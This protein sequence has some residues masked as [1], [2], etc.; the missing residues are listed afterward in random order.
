MKK[1]FLLL[2]FAFSFSFAETFFSEKYSIWQNGDYLLWTLDDSLA[3]SPSDFC[4]A[5]KKNN[6][7]I[8][9]PSCR[10]LGEWERDSVSVKY[11]KWLNN[12]FDKSLK[13]EFLKARSPLMQVKI[14][15]LED[16]IVLFL[17][18]NK[19]DIQIFLFNE[20]SNAP[21]ASGKIQVQENRIKTSDALVNEFFDKRPERRLSAKERKN[22]AEAPDP[23]YSEIP[24][25]EFWVGTS[26]AYSQARIPLTP[27]NWYR[28][29]INSKVKRYRVT[30]DSTSLWNF[31]EDE[32]AVLSF[33]GG[34]TWYG[35]FGGE[36]FYKY[37]N[38]EMKT[39]DS[40]TTYK[41]LSNWEIGM[42]ELGL[43][44]HITHTFHTLK[45]LETAP[46]F[47]FGFQYSFLTED[48]SLKKNVKKASDAYNTRIQFDDTYKGG[49]LGIGSRFLIKDSYALTLRAGV[50]TRGKSETSDPDLNSVKAPTTIGAITV[51][52]FISIGL[53]YHWKLK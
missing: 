4:I 21:I 41:E 16:K 37:S 8:G 34:A 32:S 17:T 53:E 46:F 7:N 44:L 15:A 45:W 19:N 50:S 30:K 25:A 52:G 35:I 18:K 12:N 48:I 1:I 51:D 10:E 9:S 31:M 27:Y 14:K 38:H 5:L 2:I 49:V 28:N 6:F 26:L 33:Y 29:K 47:Y 23:F 24:K 43:S 36:I 39:D 42:H 11:G 40:D 22:K 13:P 3:V 20:T